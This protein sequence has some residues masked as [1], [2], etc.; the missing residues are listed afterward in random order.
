MRSTSPAASALVGR[1]TGRAADATGIAAQAGRFALGVAVG[2]DPG[3][4]LV[5]ADEAQVEAAVTHIA[6]E[7]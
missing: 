4:C 6:E 2:R 5:V 7:L 3:E 1:F